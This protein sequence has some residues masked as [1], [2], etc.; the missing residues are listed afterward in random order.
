[1][2]TQTDAGIR[3]GESVRALARRMSAWLADANGTG[4]EQQILQLL[5][6]GEEVGELAS[7]L[8]QR[9]RR[10]QAIARETADVV[11]SALTALLALGRDI[12]DVFA[13]APGWSHED[14]GDLDGLVLCLCDYTGQMHAAVIGWT[15]QNPRKGVTHGV[16]N[17]DLML[18][19]IVLKAERL[20]AALDM[21]PAAYLA[22]HAD[23]LHARLDAL[24]VPKQH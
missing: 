18:R 1:M 8:L 20:L 11:V 13:V 4:R 6:V 7:E 24:G 21:A 16:A 10:P 15:G 5:K 12:D 22:K 9:T 19:G 17:I 23:E 3:T 14:A 2:T